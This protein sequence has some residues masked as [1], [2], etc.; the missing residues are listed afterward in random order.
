MKAIS[1]TFLSGLVATIPIVITIYILYWLG[2]SAEAMLGRMIRLVLPAGVYRPGMGVAMGLVLIFLVGV[3]LQAWI[4]RRIFAWGEAL[5]GKVPLVKTL[6]GSVRDL[7]G[8]FSGS[9]SGRFN[10]VVAVTLPN[11]PLRMLGLI[12]RENVG[13]AVPGLAAE[14]AVAVYFPM[15]YQ[16][17]G[18]TAFVPRSAVEP[19]A[20]SIN[21][22]MR[23]AVTAGM[24]AATDASAAGGAPKP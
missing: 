3:F 17:G 1:R 7:M 22:A 6:Y 24:S 13:Q 23:F 8:F 10:Q 4:F 11:S 9:S 5:L 16:I 14:D 21:A 19:L 20:M 18:Y 12:T 15:S 2:S